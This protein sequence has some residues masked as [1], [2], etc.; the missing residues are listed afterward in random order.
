ML[1]FGF[2]ATMM[3][4]SVLDKVNIKN[5]K[6]SQ[7]AVSVITVLSL[8]SMVFAVFAVVQFRY[9]F[10]GADKLPIGYNLCGIC[11]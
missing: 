10:V 2:I 9:L 7:L 1:M 3:K 4:R 11:S 8:I 6:D 5:Q